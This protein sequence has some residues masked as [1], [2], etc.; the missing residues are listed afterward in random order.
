MDNK[1][2]S[3]DLLLMRLKVLSEGTQ[4][5]LFGKLKSLKRIRSGENLF[6]SKGVTSGKF[7]C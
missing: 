3:A 5:N 6:K 4:Q 1:Q 7:D 2:K